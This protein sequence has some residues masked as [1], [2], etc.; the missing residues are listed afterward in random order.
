MIW[1]KPSSTIV[2][3]DQKLDPLNNLIT[4]AF[5]MVVVKQQ[6]RQELFRFRKALEMASPVL[7]FPSPSRSFRPP[8]LLHVRTPPQPRSGS[9]ASH[10][11]SA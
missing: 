5:A 10:P 1:C 3:I 11:S 6:R 9:P 2:R 7:L 4:S 8:V